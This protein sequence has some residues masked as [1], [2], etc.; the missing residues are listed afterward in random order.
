MHVV[1]KSKVKV[2][3]DIKIFLLNTVTSTHDRVE[4]QKRTVMEEESFD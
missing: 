4:R 3:V 1:S 2:T